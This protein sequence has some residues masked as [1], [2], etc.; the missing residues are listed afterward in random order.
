MIVL[1]I[2]NCSGDFCRHIVIFDHPNVL[3]YRTLEA[4]RC[5]Q[6]TDTGFGALARGCHELQRLDL[7]EC[8][9]VGNLQKFLITNCSFFKKYFRL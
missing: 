6:F 4:A 2:G 7:E 8:I 3:Y 9:L 1:K 5:S